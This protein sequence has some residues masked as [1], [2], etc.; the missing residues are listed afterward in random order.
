MN[1]ADQVARWDFSQNAPGIALDQY[2]ARLNNQPGGSST[3]STPYFANRAA[4]GLGGAALGYQATGSPWGAGI[5][6]VG[7]GLLGAFG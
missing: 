2:I 1:I 6:A 7:G 5:G 3:S 4:G